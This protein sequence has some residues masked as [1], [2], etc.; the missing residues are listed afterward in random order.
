MTNTLFFFAFICLAAVLLYLAIVPVDLPVQYYLAW[1]LVAVLVLLHNRPRRGWFRLV[2]LGAA[3]FVVFRYLSWR[4]FFTLGYN[5][6]LSFIGSVT[7]YVA[8]LYGIV[9]FLLSLFVNARPILRQLAPLP[10]SDDAYPGVDVLIP[11]Y[12]EDISLVKTTLVAATSIDYPRH[13]LNVYLLDDGGT[14]AKVNSSDPQRAEAASR[15]RAVLSQ[16]CREVGANYLTRADNHKAKSGNLNAALQHVR[17]ELLLVLDADHVPARDFLRKTVGYF[18][19][20]ERLF[21]VQ[22]PH[23]FVNPD[24]IEKNLEIF[25]RM[26]SENAMFYGAVQPGL[27]F[28]GSSFFCGSAAVLRREALDEC[29]G[30]AGDSITEDAE[31]ALKLHS[32]E[33]RSIYLNEPLI[34]GLH[35]ETFT[36]FMIQRM[37][38]AQGMVQIFLMQNPLRAKGLRPWQRLSYLSNM[39]FWFFP[40]SRVIFLITPMLYLLF[41]LHIYNAGIEEVFGYALPYLWALGAS[42][43]YLFG[44]FRWF[45]VSDVYETLQ[46]LF[47]LRAVVATLRN[48]RAPRFNVTPKQEQV[49]NDFISPLAAPFY[50]LAVSMLIALFFGIWRYW[51]GWGEKDILLVTMAWLTINLLVI[52]ASLGALYERR[53]RRS[54]PRIPVSFEAQLECAEARYALRINDISLGGASAILIPQLSPQA[55]ARSAVTLG[56]RRTTDDRRSHPRFP[57]NLDAELVI[58]KA[59]YSSIEIRDVSLG[60]A[61]LSRFPFG[62]ARS[63]TTGFL[64]VFHPVSQ[65]Q[66]SFPIVVRNRYADNEDLSVG[67]EFMQVE[68]RKLPHLPVNRDAESIVEEARIAQQIRH[69]FAGGVGSANKRPSLPDTGET[70]KMRVFNTAL[71]QECTLMVSLVNHRAG[72]DRHTLGLQFKPS[73]LND[74]RLLIMLVYG[75]SHRIQGMFRFPER[76]PGVFREMSLLVSVGLVHAVGHL[77]KLC[78]GAV[79]DWKTGYRS[80]TAFIRK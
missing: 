63:G 1:G 8:E 7:L 39:L 22:T 31:T 19:Q 9:M 14:D 15:R 44:R 10:E 34:S 48:P 69:I 26:P 29:G 33:W 79:A 40:F 50:L 60:G 37:R 55:E 4:T 21:L 80:A 53:Q 49:E 61:K 65:R 46:S 6:V 51:Q 16:L 54:S 57:L 66:Y 45:M 24:P 42:S 30:F 52:L 18:L 23:C 28:W 71:G 70:V 32:R 75:D 64:K 38:W 47:S 72:A 36:S 67:V 12:D 41:D 58:G 27:D 5:D 13:K 59:R 20:D 77:G 11:T 76:N 74:Y 78:G 73:N 56:D 68:R 62:L 2:Y 43:S 3:A 25:K 35:P 17:G